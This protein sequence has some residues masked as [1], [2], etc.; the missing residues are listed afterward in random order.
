M[1]QQA[2]PP[3]P[4]ACADAGG[5]IARLRRVLTLVEEMADRASGPAVNDAL[6]EAAR[7]SAAHG[8]ALPIV[9]RHFDRLAAE[10]TASAA[11]GMR[12]LLALQDRERPTRAAADRLADE[13]ARSL[14]R[15]RLTLPL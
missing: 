2:A 1:T 13:L 4:L 8:C 6:D 9:Q 3:R 12:A 5:Q 11:A 15:L 10:T 14:E 7:I